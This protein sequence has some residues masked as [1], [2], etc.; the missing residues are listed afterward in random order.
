MTGI[1]HGHILSPICV[2]IP[3]IKSVFAGCIKA[4]EIA[5]RK[6]YNLIIC[7]YQTTEGLLNMKQFKKYWILLRGVPRKFS[8]FK[9]K[10]LWKYW[11]KN[12]VRCF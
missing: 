4:W 12:S 10:S 1:R 5:F 8:T 11:A 9:L 7:A 3:E 2:Y 6:S